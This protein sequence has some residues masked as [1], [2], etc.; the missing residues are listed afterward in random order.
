MDYLS[1]SRILKA[2][3]AIL[4]D[5][6]F[7]PQKSNA[8]RVLDYLQKY[9]VS[10]LCNWD[11]NDFVNSLDNITSYNMISLA[12]TLKKD[13]L[14]TNNLNEINRYCIL[15]SNICGQGCRFYDEGKFDQLSDLIDLVH[16]LPEALINKE[17]WNPKK[18]WKIYF[19]PY[20]KK[21]DKNFLKI[22]QKKLLKR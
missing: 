16:G 18:F 12:E 10:N 9:Y 6:R 2:T 13:T 19:N 15:I 22:E 11:Y 4:A 8:K 14:P 17:I 20:R 7:N 5:I 21:W 1:I 3:T